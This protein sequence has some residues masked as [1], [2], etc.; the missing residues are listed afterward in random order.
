MTKKIIVLE[1]EDKEI[2]LWSTLTNAC[3]YHKD[4][5]YHTIKKIQF[6]YH[7]K[8]Y[9]FKKIELNYKNKQI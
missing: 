9:D 3:D 2:E 4:F 7:H 8:G 6:P 1:S 5:Q